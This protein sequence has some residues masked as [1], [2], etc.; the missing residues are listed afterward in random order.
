MFGWFK[1]KPVEA[2]G[3][4]LLHRWYVDVADV[5][6]GANYERRYEVVRHTWD[7]IHGDWCNERTVARFAT[8][9]D[10]RAF[11][12]KHAHLPQA[13]DIQKTYEASK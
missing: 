5:W 8:E 11:I 2:T 4:N 3:P 10:A 6:D 9:V 13:F 1:R 7:P 12:D